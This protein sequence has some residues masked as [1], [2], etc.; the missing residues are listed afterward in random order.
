MTAGR[1]KE[2]N[3]N[4]PVLAAEYLASAQDTWSEQLHK[5]VVKIPTIEGLAIHLGVARSTLYLWAEQYPEFSDMLERLKMFQAERLINKGLSG[6]YAPQIAK[7]ILG[8]HGYSD[9]QE[10]DMT[11][12]GEK[13]GLSAEDQAKL[14]KL[15]PPKIEEHEPA[16]PQPKTETRA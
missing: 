16:V 12:K 3:E 7:L 4:I 5:V 13:I 15:F 8:K 14:N 11:S 10:V 2:Y 6:D 9:K 1:P